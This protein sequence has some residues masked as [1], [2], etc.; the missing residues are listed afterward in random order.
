MKVGLLGGSFNPI[1]IGHIS[2]AEAALKT[3]H[4]DQIWFIPTGNHPL[5]RNV[6]LLD[7]SK[8][9]KLISKVIAKYNNFKLS[10]LDSNKETVNYT[11]D[12]IKRLK[13]VNPQYDFYFLIGSDILGELTLWHKYKWLLENIKFAVIDRPGANLTHSLEPEE[14]S[15]LVFVDMKPVPISSTEIREII[16]KD[17]PIKGLVPEIIE[18]DIYNFYKDL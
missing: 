15:K 12:L 16:K 7:F 9:L 1:H 3:L 14:I 18:A 4:L 10:L 2:I 8:R 13:K 5:K 6:E 11:Y 17:Q